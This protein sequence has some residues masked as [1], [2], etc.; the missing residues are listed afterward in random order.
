MARASES[1][2]Y[3]EEYLHLPSGRS[4]GEEEGMPTLCANS[5]VG[6]TDVPKGGAEITRPLIF[7]GHSMGGVVVAKVRRTS[8]VRERC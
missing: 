1:E 8:S 4:E 6:C 7:I 5:P 2:S 3:N